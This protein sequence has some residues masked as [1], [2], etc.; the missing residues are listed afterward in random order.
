MQCGLREAARQ[1]QFDVVAEIWDLPWNRER[2]RWAL[3]D[4]VDECAPGGPVENLADRESEHRDADDTPS[5]RP[6][7]RVEVGTGGARQQDA[8]RAR[9]GIHGALH[10]AE[11]TRHHM[12]F[13]KKDRLVEAAQS[14]IGICP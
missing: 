14:S 1:R 7:L 9:I 3:G 11:D 2:S 10:S 12:P 6:R 4:A 13:V 5:P 8:P